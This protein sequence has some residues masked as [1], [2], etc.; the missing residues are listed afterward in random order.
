[1]CTNARMN[2]QT[3]IYTMEH[4]SDTKSEVLIHVTS[5]RSLENIMLSVISQTQSHMLLGFFYVIYT[6]QANPKRQKA[7]QRKP[8]DKGE[9]TRNDYFVCMEY[10][11]GVMEKFSILFVC[12]LFDCAAQHAGSQFPNPGSNLNPLSERAE[13]TTGLPGKSWKSFETG[14]S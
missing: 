13:S 5:W 6:Q 10:S 3:M 14:E 7:D 12:L 8:R 9:R 1:M 2:K 11:Y 4:Q